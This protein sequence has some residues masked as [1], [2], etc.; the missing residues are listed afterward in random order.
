[1]FVAGVSLS[2]GSMETA[3]RSG[4]ETAA[5]IVEEFKK[6]PHA[7]ESQKVVA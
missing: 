2:V 6:Q 3:L 4:R 7:A 1:V 5:L